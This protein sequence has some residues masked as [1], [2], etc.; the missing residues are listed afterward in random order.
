MKK[1]KNAVTAAFLSLSLTVLSGCSLLGTNETKP[2]EPLSTTESTTQ[3]EATAKASEATTAALVTEQAPTT[4][5]EPTTEPTPAE[6]PEPTQAL[7][8]TT[9]EPTPA[10]TEALTEPTTG[11]VAETPKKPKYIFLFIGDGMGIGHIQAA[12]Y[13]KAAVED[14]KD[15]D[16]AKTS[17]AGSLLN[18][19]Q[20]PVVGSVVNYNGDSFITDSAAAITAIT[21]GHK[22]ATD[23]IG[24]NADG[25][26]RYE[27]IAEKVKSRLGFKVGVVS[28][29]N[30]NHAT[31]AGYYGHQVNRTMYYEL[32]LDMLASGFDYL[33]G[34]TIRQPTGADGAQPDL[35][36]LAKAQ[37]YKVYRDKDAALSKLKEGMG[38]V[39]IT[40]E[41]RGE[42]EAMRLRVDAEK[43]S[44]DLSDYVLGGLKVLGE[45]EGFF[46]G[47]E[48][49]LIDWASHENDAGAIVREVLD[50]EKAVGVALAFYNAHPEETLIL[51]TADHETGGMGLG[52]S[53]MGYELYLQGLENQKLS[54]RDF[55]VKVALEYRPQKASWEQVVWDIRS[56][57][58]L[59]FDGTFQPGD[60]PKL[61]MTN[62]EVLQLN[63]AYLA[64]MK[65]ETATY[66]TAMYESYGSYEPLAFTATTILAKKC[67]VRFTTIYHTGEPIPIYAIGA[68]AEEFSGTFDNTEITKKLERLLGIE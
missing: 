52:Y 54:Y 64:S 2:V 38:K 19:E 67:G 24:V 65:N 46:F 39:L 28:N 59:T 8:P 9:P 12:S 4:A 27:T 7:E 10:E 56:F 62:D 42:G 49:G 22:T 15:Y 50:L 18:F 53:N 5:P 20:F 23:A 14:G 43:G 3:A 45:Q 68:G 21:T 1:W 34:G 30:I 36:E 51:V 60:D 40:S 17:Y 48:G 41:Q 29:A 61:K 47:I 63:A 35:Y 13:Y 25:T 44:A 55:M 37:G 31:P 6:T 26:E 33:G 16:P 57:F 32:G 66:G 11:P 58:G